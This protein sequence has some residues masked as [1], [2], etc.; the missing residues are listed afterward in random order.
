MKTNLRKFHREGLCRP[1]WLLFVALWLAMGG[2]AQPT[3]GGE[4][5]YGHQEP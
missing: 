1:L 2:Y 5:G 4:S 3:G